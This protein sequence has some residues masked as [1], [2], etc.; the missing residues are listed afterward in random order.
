MKKIVQGEE[1]TEVNH[2]EE[3]I[4]ILVMEDECNANVDNVVEFKAIS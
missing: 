2:G 4:H 1:A 3:N